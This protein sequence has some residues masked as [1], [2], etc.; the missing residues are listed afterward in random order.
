M[1]GE[2]FKDFNAQFEAADTIANEINRRQRSY[3]IS[4][5]A[6]AL[7]QLAVLHSSLSFLALLFA[8]VQVALVISKFPAPSHQRVHRYSSHFLIDLFDEF[9]SLQENARL[10]GV[11]FA[12]ERIIVGLN[13]HSS[14]YARSFSWFARNLQKGFVLETKSNREEI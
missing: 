1:I 14:P 7:R 9:F 10:R 12:A 5:K 11:F 8:L 13:E 3:F 6:L 4:L 2:K